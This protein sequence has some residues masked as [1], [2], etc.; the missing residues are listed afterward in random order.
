MGTA[1]SIVDAALNPLAAGFTSGQVY[2]VIK[3][4]TFIDVAPSHW[5][6]SYIERLYMAGVT[7]GCAAVPLAYCP[8]TPTTRAQMAVMLLRGK[9]GAEYVPPAVGGSTGFGDVPTSHWAAA[10]IKQLAA[11]GITSGCGGG[12]FCPDT[13][14]TR[15]QV[16]ILLV[17][18][19][20]GTD[21]VPQT[22][23]GIFDDVA[24]GS[25]GADYIEQLWIDGVTSG[26][27]A[28][29][30]CPNAVINRDSIAVFL[31]RAFNLP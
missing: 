9:Y 22:A 30:F 8:N 19:A 7:G 14:V 15:A 5:A 23:T 31:V 24:V 13:P 25:F 27:G 16:A 28:G 3:A 21:F 26:C 17:R 11:E 10:W 12:N 2:S 29:N 4:P 18:A 6:Y 1:G 20:H